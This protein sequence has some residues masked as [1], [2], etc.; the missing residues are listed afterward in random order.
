[1]IPRFLT[2]IV[3]GACVL[4]APATAAQLRLK[5]AAV[6][7]L[8][9]SQGCS[10]CPPA[11]ALLTQLNKRD[12]VV[13]LAYHVDYWDYIGWSD[14]FG[15]K[16]YSDLQRAYA[17]SQGED[18]IYTPQMMV[19]G[20]TDIVG[21]HEG[22]VTRAIRRASLDVPV[23]LKADGGMLHVAIPGKQGLPESAVWLVKYR[24]HASVD[25]SRG[26]N[27]G[28]ELS[29]SQIVTGRQVLGMWDPKTGAEFK[30]PVGDLLDGDS[31][32]VAIVVQEEPDGLPGRVLGAA[33][34][35]K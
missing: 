25:I 26:E 4:A 18:R 27:G 1:M 24:S 34:F 3:L 8:F 5:P 23:G 22:E 17:R 13:A 35:T 33:S 10:S 11:D 21:S 12:D 9:T 7:E 16:A 31:D 15:K 14:T 32:G 2:T 20:V 19:N 30:L 6:L 29:Y 28:R